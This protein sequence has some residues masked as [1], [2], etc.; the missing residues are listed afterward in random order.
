MPS[1]PRQDRKTTR[2]LRPQGTG[3]RDNQADGSL[4]RLLR[5]IART[6]LIVVDDWGLERLKDSQ[7]L[8]VLEILEDR[9]DRGSLLITSQ[10]AVST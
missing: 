10:F 6:D 9:Q 5:K 1:R 4:V 7:A 2:P 8:L 3:S